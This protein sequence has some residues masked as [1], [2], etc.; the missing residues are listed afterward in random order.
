MM[1]TLTVSYPE[2]LE[3][4]THLSSAAFQA[5]ARMAMAVKLYELGTLTSG[6]AAALAGVSRVEFL[7]ECPRYGTPSVDWDEDE[8][9]AEGRG[10]RTS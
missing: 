9:K 1:K 5:R 2:T 8:L 6:Q 7:L 10:K 4:V 3:A